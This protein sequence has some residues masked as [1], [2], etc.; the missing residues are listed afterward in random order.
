MTT[1]TTTLTEFLLARI[2][3][4]EAAARDGGADAMTGHRWK[5]APEDVYNEL[6]RVVIANSRRV[7][8]ECAAKRK[9]VESYQ[10]RCDNAERLGPSTVGETLLA[11]QHCK[12]LAS[13][14]ADHSDYRQ[15]WVS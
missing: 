4:D 12:T 1:Q 6:Q 13:V 10:W 2:A 11:Q 9:I 15:E 3:D 5:H 7:L 8:A 14:Y